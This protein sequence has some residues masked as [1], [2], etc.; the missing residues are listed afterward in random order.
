M[1][2]DLLEMP[3][4]LTARAPTR[5]LRAMF[6]HRRFRHAPRWLLAT[7][8]ALFVLGHACELPAY[9]GLLTAALPSEHD[10]SDAHEH[11]SELSCEPLDAVR[12]PASVQAMPPPVHLIVL[13][14]VVTD[15]SRFS[16]D[17]LFETRHKPPGRPALFVLHASLLI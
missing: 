1:S 17:A 7:L 14:P 11:D 16:R 10:E 8:C 15:V 4:S 2:S 6:R 3:S 9:A 12:A 13:A 5:K